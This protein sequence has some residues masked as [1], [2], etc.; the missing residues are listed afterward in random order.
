MRSPRGTLKFL[1]FL[2][3]FLAWGWLLW[4]NNPGQPP[5]SSSIARH[6]W[7]G[8]QSSMWF[9]ALEALPMLLAAWAAL[10]ELPLTRRLPHSIGVCAFLG[11]CAA[12]GE[13]RWYSSVESLG[14]LRHLVTVY[15]AALGGLLFVR[16]FKWSVGSPEKTAVNCPPQVSL[17]MVMIWTL[18]IGVWIALARATLPRWV[19][20]HPSVS[21]LLDALLAYPLTVAALGLPM[22]LSAIGL[23]L[24]DRHRL[25]F[26]FGLVA[27]TCGV[28]TLLS[29][30]Y[31]RATGGSQWECQ[32]L[33]AT[34]EVIGFVAATVGS[35]LVVR[36]AGS[37]LKWR[38]LALT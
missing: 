10:S 12:W 30:V 21:F 1:L 24:A 13:M 15:P 14:P 27:A 9:G 32:I 5:I 36:C 8:C 4:L 22:I 35:V 18:A 31:V 3:L 37:R 26:G 33:Y 7:F 20:G 34:S 23:V 2:G 17:R 16:W 28:T 19:P 25:R 11:L 6:V 38:G 29:V